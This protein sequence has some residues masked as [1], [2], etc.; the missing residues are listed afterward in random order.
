[1]IAAAVDVD[2]AGSALAVVAAFLGAG[3]ADGLAQAVKERGAR[4]NLKIKLLSVDTEADRDCAFYGFRGGGRRC[5]H[6][7]RC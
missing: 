3:Q 2:G 6:Q 5:T 1:M 4:I 7:R